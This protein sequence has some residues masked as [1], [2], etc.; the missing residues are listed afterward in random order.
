MRKITER[1]MIREVR[2]KHTR[3]YG[4]WSRDSTVYP[5][6]GPVQIGTI[7]DRLKALDLETCSAADVDKAIGRSGW[8]ELKCDA[9]DTPVKKIVRIGAEPDYEARWQDLCR[10]C[11]IKALKIITDPRNDAVT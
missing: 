11:L 9:C 4:A 7:R 3:Q 6:E 2:E 1:D 8:A 10:E 5:L